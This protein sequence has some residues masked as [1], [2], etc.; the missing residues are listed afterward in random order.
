MPED[1]N[2]N[3]RDRTTQAWIDLVQLELGSIQ[4]SARSLS[5]QLMEYGFLYVTPSELEKLTSI[6]QF[7]HSIV[8]TITQRRK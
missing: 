7:L 2:K 4:A 8:Q 6:E 1:K 5:A 3:L